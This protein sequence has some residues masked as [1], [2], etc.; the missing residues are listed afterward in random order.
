MTFK[1]LQQRQPGFTLIM[2]FFRLFVLTHWCEA[3]K[4]RYRIT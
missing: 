3:L 2:A 4:N 1:V